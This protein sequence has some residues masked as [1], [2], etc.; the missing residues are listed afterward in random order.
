MILWGDTHGGNH[1]KIRDDRSCHG[2]AGA[3]RRGELKRANLA[4][5]GKPEGHIAE[6]YPDREGSLRATPGTLVR[7]VPSPRLRLWPVLVR[8]LLAKPY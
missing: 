5:G 8:S 4:R 3:R 2:R 7:L 1:A 6:L